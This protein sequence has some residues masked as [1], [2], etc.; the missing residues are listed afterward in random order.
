M[1]ISTCYVLA[2]RVG[3]AILSRST[4]RAITR[5]TEISRRSGRVLARFRGQSTVQR[6]STSAALSSIAWECRLNV[7][8]TVRRVRCHVARMIFNPRVVRGLQKTFCSAPTTG[9]C[10]GGTTPTIGI[11]GGRTMNRR[12][13][14]ACVAL[15]RVDRST[16]R[17]RLVGRILQ[18]SVLS[19]SGTGASCAAMKVPHQLRSV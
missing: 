9:C 11:C 5:D 13:R 3:A 10:R 8:L 17:M 4:T 15:F 16:Y 6:K 18:F 19:H 12:E 14:T 2:L 1:G 7:C